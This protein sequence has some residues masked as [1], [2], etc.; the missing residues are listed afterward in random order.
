MS[1][2]CR[3]AFGWAGMAFG[4]TVCAVT[5]T[6]LAGQQVAVGP[7]N[8]A[9]QAAG[10][11]AFDP[12]VSWYGP[13]SAIREAKFTRVTNAEQWAKLWE[14]HEGKP[15]AVDNVGAP[16]I[17]RINFE[18]CMVIGVFQGATVN[19]N[20]V[21]I[22]GVAEEPDCIRVRYG[23]MTYQT[24]GG[25]N[26]GGGGAVKVTPFGIFVVPRSNKPIVIE[27]NVQGLKDNPAQWKARA[28]L[29]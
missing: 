17:P 12:L 18:K 22:E 8:A 6:V 1:R 2:S 27:E 10:K 25:L 21:L 3:A 24:A 26:G 19:S 11:G 14:E 13:K 7:G 15:T 29:E 23:E 4:L 28:K 9:P 5:A 16:F 20:G